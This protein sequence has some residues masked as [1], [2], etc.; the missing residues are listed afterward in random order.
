MTFRRDTLGVKRTI[1]KLVDT[2]TPSRTFRFE[3]VS[4]HYPLE[5]KHNFLN[6]DHRMWR[7]PALYD[8]TSEES[9]IDLYVKAI[10]KAK[11]MVCASFDYLNG[12]DIDLDAIFKNNSYLTGLDCEKYKELKYFEF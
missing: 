12:K 6:S 7:N 1:Y 9:F 4:Y 5:D 11:I 2:F 3:A 10:K 8:R